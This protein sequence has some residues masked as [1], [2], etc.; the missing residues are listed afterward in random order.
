[1]ASEERRDTLNNARCVDGLALELK[2]RTGLVRMLSCWCKRRSTT[3]V[4]HDVKEA[5]VYLGLIRELDLDLVQ[6]GQ[7]ILDV[8]RRLVGRGC[9]Q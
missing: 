9:I 7:G 8:E 4:F 3:H 5:V 1:M 2:E 6:I